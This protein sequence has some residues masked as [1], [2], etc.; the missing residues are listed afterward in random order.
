MTTVTA[1]RLAS[2]YVNTRSPVSIAQTGQL[3]RFVVFSG[4]LASFAMLAICYVG[5]NQRGHHRIIHDVDVAFELTC[6]PPEPSFRAV[7]QLVP[8]KFE[9]GAQPTAV[10]TKPEV[11]HSSVEQQHQVTDKKEKVKPHMIAAVPE[12]APVALAQPSLPQQNNPVANVLSNP[13]GG[14]AASA[15]TP[16]A[17]SSP[18]GG[19]PDGSVGA[20]GA[21][22]NGT[23]AGKGDSNSLAG[24]DFGQNQL[25]TMRTAPVA[26]GNIGP[27]KRDLVARIK[28]AWHPEED[29]EQVVVELALSQ[30]GKLLNRQLLQSTGSSTL[31]EQLLSA[32]DETQF[33]ALPEWYRGAQLKIKLVLKNT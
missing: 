29:Y 1:V 28:Q 33:A 24:A 15:A 10:G 4:I 32:I 30:E 6:A 31:D 23:G 16:V 18:A 3:R 20:A 11:A 12:Q 21:G 13:F 27:Y 2:R 7:D 26:M 19:S 22:G 14:A 5:H 17:E 25:V 9:E 8:L